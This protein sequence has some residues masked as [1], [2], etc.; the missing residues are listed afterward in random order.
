MNPIRMLVFNILML[1]V[2]RC[3]FG[4]S[5]P[6]E[7]MTYNTRYKTA[8]CQGSD[9]G[10]PCPSKWSNMN[11]S[12]SSPAAIYRRGETIDVIWVRNSH[13]GGMVRLGFVPVSAMWNS[14]AHS[15][16]AL[17]YGCWDDVRIRCKV[18]NFR[19]CGT[20]KN[21]F[22]LTT[23]LKVPTCL[24]D[25]DYVFAY[26][27]FGGLHFRRK[28]GGFPD[29][30]HCSHVRISGGPPV[31]GFCTPVFKVGTGPS[32]SRDGTKC[33]TS[34]SAPG[35]CVKKEC[36][37][38]SFYSKPKAFIPN[39]PPSF[40]ARD[41]SYV[42]DNPRSPLT[43][44]PTGGSDSLP[45]TTPPPGSPPAHSPDAKRSPAPENRAAKCGAG[46][47]CSPGCTK[48]AG[49]DCH[50]HKTSAGD[51]CCT[52]A[53]IKTGRSCDK[54]GPPCVCRGRS[55]K[56][57]PKFNDGSKPAPSPVDENRNPNGALCGAGVCCS[58]GCKKCG[59]PNC[60]LWKTNPS[61]KCCIRSVQKT[62]RSC[63]THSPP[64][65]CKHGR[66]KNCPSQ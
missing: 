34:A 32:A 11:N 53:V 57:C 24:P 3:V 29:F 16:L 41:V 12:V 47:C 21:G 60:Q 17:F 52:R 31:S 43:K 10:S 20:D 15:R 45:P 56:H 23:K 8:D 46:V 6:A 33:L 19:W 22:A 49:H 7:P 27:W 2:A 14:A 51:L 13:H 50:R 63:E 39:P 25:G 55:P 44:W 30:N 40:T 38:N 48:C 4:H 65:V 61:Q 58:P 66:P 5:W 35:Q 1:T 62:G 9:C 42:A 64:C 28:K 37:V 54:F 59:G 36:A 18:H 26:S